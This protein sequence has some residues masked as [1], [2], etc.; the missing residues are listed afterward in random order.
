MSRLQKAQLKVYDKEDYVAME[1]CVNPANAGHVRFI[2]TFVYWYEEGKLKCDYQDFHD[3]DTD[4]EREEKM[5]ELAKR[6][7]IEV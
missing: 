2:S 1:I 7:G 5:C 3:D 4:S 6:L